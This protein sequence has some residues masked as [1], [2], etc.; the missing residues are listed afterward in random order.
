MRSTALLL[1][2]ALGLVLSAVT[3]PAQVRITGRPI[4]PAAPRAVAATELV[5]QLLTGD[6]EGARAY[7]HER[8]AASFDSTA[9]ETQLAEILAAI[10]DEGAY[11]L[12]RLLGTEGMVMAQLRDTRGGSP[13]MV[14]VELEEREPYPVAGLSMIRARMEM[15]TRQRGDPGGD[16][17]R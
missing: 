9:A 3:A 13:I 6:V 1:S 16:P 4:D 7:L 11:L 5:Q 14:M 8:R 2:L 10:G 15:R 17:A 12:E